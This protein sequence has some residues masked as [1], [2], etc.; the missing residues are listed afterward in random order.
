MGSNTVLLSVY[1][2]VGQCLKSHLESRYPLIE[3]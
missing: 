1:D 2:P 3:I